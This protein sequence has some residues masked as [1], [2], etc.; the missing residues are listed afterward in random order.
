MK[1]L[2]LLRQG[3]YYGFQYSYGGAKAGLYN[4]SIMTSNQLIDKLGVEAKVKVVFDA[5]SIDR[6]VSI[7]RPNIVILEALWVTPQKLKEIKALHKNVKFVVRIHSEV[8]FLANEGI[9]VEWIKEYSLIPGVIVGLNSILAY[10]DF[11]RATIGDYAYLPNIY[12]DVHLPKTNN[13]KKVINKIAKIFLGNPSEKEIKKV[14]KIVNIGSFGAIRPLKNNLIQA[15]AAIEFGNLFNKTIVFHVNSSR[16][17]HGGETV[18]RNIRS[19][20]EGGPH[21]LVEHGWLPRPAFLQLVSEMDL[22]MQLSFN[23]SFN[24]VAADFVQQRVPIIVSE[25]IEW[26]PN[27]AK[28]STIDSSKIVDKIAH[29]VT[30]PQSLNLLSRIYL[31]KYNIEATEEWEEFLAFFGL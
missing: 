24:I 29:A 12:E 13:I 19:L 28:T 21:V 17:E 8:P 25:T 15:F 9:G 20:F 3:D 16:M 4:S 26:M 6:E 7:Y 18:V 1:I 31:N 22:G 23:E 30:H 10:N 11:Q 14:S 27:I 2:F 5:N